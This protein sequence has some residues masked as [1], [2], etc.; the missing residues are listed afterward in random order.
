MHFAPGNGSLSQRREERGPETE[1]VLKTSV[2]LSGS[3]RRPQRW[4][5]PAKITFT[6]IQSEKQRDRDNPLLFQP[7]HPATKRMTPWSN[8]E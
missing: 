7:R 1:W 6:N 8:A 4:H 5:R 2:K 3:E